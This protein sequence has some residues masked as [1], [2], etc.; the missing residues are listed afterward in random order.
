M[1][2]RELIRN[3]SLAAAS[4]P[5]SR[6]AFALSG[7]FPA[8]AVKPSDKLTVACIGVGSQGLRVLL[9]VLRLP[10]VQIVA[11]CD[12]NRGSSDYLD[13]GPNELRDKVR[14]VL[15]DRSW[16]DKHPGPTAGREVAQS[17]VNA[18]YAKER[19]A[20]DYRGCAAYEDYREL[21]AK[22]HDLDAVIISTPDHW[23]ALI[24]IAAM[25]AGKH[26]YSQKPMA[27]SVWEA[28][29][30]A[31]VAKETGRATQVSI[32]NSDSIASKQVHDLIAGGAI[33]HVR[34]ID[35]WTKRA[36]AFWKQGLPT[37]THA[38]P[39][40]DG[41]NW[42]MWLG[43]APMRPFSRSYLP[44]IWRA[45]YDFGCGAVGDMGEY[46]FD[47]IDRAVGLGVAAERVEA[48]TTDLFPECYPVASS[49]HFQFGSTASRPALKLNWFDGG[50]EPAR[51]SELP[52]DAPM[53]TG[54]E[55]VIYT[56]DHGKLMTAY[57]GEDPRIL[58]QNGNAAGKMSRPYGPPASAQIPFQPARPELGAS[59][60]SA[61]A[62]H[63]LEWI[64]ACHGG[65]P[66]R[67]NYAY[68]APIVETLLLGCIAVRTHESLAWDAGKFAFTEGSERASS[69]LKPHY[70]SPYSL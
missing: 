61:D 4:I 22:E 67:A 40:P 70:R 16:G 68:E 64:A 20:P 29:E 65:P 49:V 53:G 50:I 60:S 34:S 21:L 28:R 23:H 5:P 56:G 33:G 8:N 19:G 38:D 11:V 3:L 18:F 48:S 10:E 66:A 69:L 37:P 42:D 1:N 13:W 24:A 27:H 6:A 46:G 59:A 14:T 54:G 2:R 52:H 58:S 35:I 7:F 31:R 41:L 12:V 36:S 32:F 51:P 47:T 43:P 17:I 26:V 55:G 45:W 15:Q 63:Y 9:D 57:M 30:M 39:I 44:F 25:R 62:P